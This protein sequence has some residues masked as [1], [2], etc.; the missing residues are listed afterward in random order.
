MRFDSRHRELISQIAIMS[1]FEIAAVHWAVASQGR[2]H[3]IHEES[4][5]CA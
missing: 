5:A 2:G 1:E 4:N 3:V